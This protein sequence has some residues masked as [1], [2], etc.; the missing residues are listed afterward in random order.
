MASLIDLI[1]YLALSPGTKLTD[2]IGVTEL[3]DLF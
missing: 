3:D 1:Y 2:K